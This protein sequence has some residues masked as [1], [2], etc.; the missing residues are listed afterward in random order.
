M[1]VRAIGHHAMFNNDTIPIISS[2]TISFLALTIPCI[3]INMGVYKAITPIN[4][5]R[6]SAG[7]L[8]E[9]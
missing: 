2:L 1:M 6:T 9:Y 3:N 8:G 4:N 5:T 7:D